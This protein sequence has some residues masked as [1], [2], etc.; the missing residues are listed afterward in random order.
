LPE[1]EI[2]VTIKETI[3]DAKRTFPIK[4]LRI[5]DSKNRIKLSMRKAGDASWRNITP[6]EIVQIKTHIFRAWAFFNCP[7]TYNSSN[8]TA[9]IITK[10]LWGLSFQ[11]VILIGPKKGVKNSAE[12][13]INGFKSDFIQ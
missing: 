4:N 8:L 11:I 9:P 2:I 5:K 3:A 1:K 12:V 13:M 10:A 6:R 7:L